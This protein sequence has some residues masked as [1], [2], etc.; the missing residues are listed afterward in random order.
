MFDIRTHK[1]PAEY[2]EVQ[3]IWSAPCPSLNFRTVFPQRAVLPHSFQLQIIATAGMRI[4]LSG[5]IHVSGSHRGRLRGDLGPITVWSTPGG[6]AGKQEE[7]DA[8]TC[9]HNQVR[10]REDSEERKQKAEG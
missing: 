5:C 10:V 6:F 2:I 3:S 4:L 9:H 8:W 7:K 1:L